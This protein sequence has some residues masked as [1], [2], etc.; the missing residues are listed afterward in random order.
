MNLFL[1]LATGEFCMNSDEEK[2]I[3]CLPGLGS[4]KHNNAPG[5]R[6]DLESQAASKSG[7][8]QTLDGKQ[9]LAAIPKTKEELGSDKHNSNAPGEKGDL[10]S[11]AASKSGNEQTLDAKQLLAAI[12]KTKEEL[13]SD[14]HNNN[15]PREKG[16]LESQAASKS[17]NEQTLD[18]K[19]LL[20]AIPKTKEELF[21]YDIEW[22]ICDKVKKNYPYF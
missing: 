2:G 10:E 19:Q 4:D 6:G 3:V 9:L 11:Q 20:A 5:E 13:G 21:A 22:A 18:A 1:L 8:E 12:P 17:G 7:N 15:A 16:D 14:K